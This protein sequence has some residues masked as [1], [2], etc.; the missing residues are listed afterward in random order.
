MKVIALLPIKNEAWVLE[1]TLACLSAFCDVILVN[2]QQSED[3]SHAIASRFPKVVWIE[4][5]ESK[6]C[7]QARWH[8]WDVARHY[9]GC[10]LLWCT[11][12]DELFSPRMAA[13][14]LQ[15]QR[16]ALTPGTIVECLYCHLWHSPGRYRAGLGAYSPY[17]KPI[18]IVDDRRTGYDRSRALPLHEERVPVDA[19]APRVKAAGVP[20]LHLQWLLPNRSQTRQAWYRCREWLQGGKPAVAI[21]E[22]YAHTLPQWYVPT[23]PVPAE[24]LDGVTLPGTA[25]DVEPSWQD[26]EILK[27]FDERGIEFFEPL[28]IWQAPGLG[29]EFRRRVGR[30]PTPDRSYLPPWSTR[31]Q[32]MGRRV[33][34]AVRRRLIPER[35]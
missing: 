2:D 21:N 9:D 23:A 32:R 3:G 7:E 19:N 35:T 1:H 29:R 5:S 16:E 10:N 24:W 30:S 4:S 11:D 14:L 12:A 20:V 27:S 34:H 26:A 31:A 17:W 22:T 15:R 6:I 13:G 25:V 8:L 28:E 18:A 33:F